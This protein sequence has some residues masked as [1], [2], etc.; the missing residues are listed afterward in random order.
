MDSKVLITVYMPLFILLF[1][2]LP[3]QNE[4]Q[5]LMIIKMIIKRRKRKGWI[6]MT[7]DIIKKFVGKTCKISTGPF[8]TYI[9]GKII[10][11]K[12]NWIEIETKSGKELIN[13]EF[14]L[15]IKIKQ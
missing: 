2:I 5:K 1:V 8:G 13:S 4:L 3:Q 11:I 10:D 6:I 12:E 14:V 9:V 7:N 15:T